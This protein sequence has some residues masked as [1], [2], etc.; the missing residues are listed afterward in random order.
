[1][2]DTKWIAHAMVRDELLGV[3]LHSSLDVSDS[4]TI[5][6][7]LIGIAQQ[8]VIDSTGRDF[9]AG[10]VEYTETIDGGQD[11]FIPAHTPIIS[12]TSV[13]VDDDLLDADNYY[14]YGFKID[15]AETL[16]STSVLAS[17]KRNV[18]IV[19]KAGYA[20][21]PDVIK[22]AVAQIVAREIL[23]ADGSAKSG[24]AA[25]VTIT[26]V[27]TLK[28]GTIRGQLHEARINNLECSISRILSRYRQPS[29]G[30]V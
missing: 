9:V 10:G 7:T 11:Y 18:V 24:G 4:S 12:V 1:M 14:V 17:G 23:I 22:R 28:F 16:T 20:A 15:F 6:P 25:E 29:I 8:L 3:S 27:A 2:A 19:Y 26:G 30:V 5:L 21:V 13:T